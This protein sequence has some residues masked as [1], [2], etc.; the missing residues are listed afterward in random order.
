MSISVCILMC[1]CTYSCIYIYILS[2][3]DSFI[4]SQLISVARHMKCFKWDQNP[5]HFMTA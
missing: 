3:T 5:A 2:S 4:V 1:V